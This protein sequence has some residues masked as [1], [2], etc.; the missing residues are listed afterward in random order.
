MSH[1]AARSWTNKLWFWMNRSQGSIQRYGGCGS[2]PLLVPAG[3]AVGARAER[4]FHKH[5]I[6]ALPISAQP[7]MQRAPKTPRW[8]R[9]LPW[10]PWAVTLQS[11]AWD[12]A[13]HVVL[14]PL[15][16]VCGLT[17]FA[18]VHLVP[19][20]HADINKV[21][22]TNT[23]CLSS[24]LPPAL[25]LSK[26]DHYV[27]ARMPCSDIPVL[28]LAFLLGWA[29]PAL[30]CNQKESWEVVLQLVRNEMSWWLEGLGEGKG[31]VDY[32]PH[33]AHRFSIRKIPFQLSVRQVIEI[34][35]TVSSQASTSHLLPLSLPLTVLHH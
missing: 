7:A 23:P 24:S 14:D 25:T 29:M 18:A 31:Q 34:T 2:I 22:C 12:C 3:E 8:A 26:Y 6:T 19:P 10:K 32:P 16:N 20:R 15:P 21:T 28:V 27:P 13:S 35:K 11:S 1:S 5:L 4:P 33:I 9:Q 17:S 30:H